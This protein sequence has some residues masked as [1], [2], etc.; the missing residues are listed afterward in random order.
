M[1]LWQ[2]LLNDFPREGEGTGTGT[3]EAKPWY[4]GNALVTPELVGHWQNRGLH[5][6]TPQEIAIAASIA[7]REAEKLIGAPASEMLRLPK[8]A[9]APEWNQVWERLGRPKEAKD[10]DFSAVK[11]AKGEAPDQ[12]TLDHYRNLAFTLNMP[13]DAAVRFAQDNIKHL[14]SVSTAQAAIN[15]DKVAQEKVKLADNWKSNFEANMVIAK[16]GA[17]KLGLPPE[18]VDA[19]E[20]VVGYADTM[21]ALRKVGMGTQ[22]ASFITHTNQN[23]N[24]GMLTKEAAMARKSELKADNAWVTRYLNGG[25]AEAKEIQALDRIIVGVSG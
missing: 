7:H 2:R 12:A 8:D 9:N 10:Y 17:A 25:A 4:D 13:K 5:D 24:G 1:M 21:E 19:L 22:E 20:K 18:A 3:G 14:D 11:N 16:A 15:Q 6:K 23:L